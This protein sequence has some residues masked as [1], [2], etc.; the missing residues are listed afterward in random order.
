[1]DTYLYLLVHKEHTKFKIGL[2]I[3]VTDRS[4]RLAREQGDFD[5]DES[6]TIKNNALSISRLEKTLHFIF[7]DWNLRGNNEFEGHTEW[8]SI[9]CL[10]DVIEEIKRIGDYQGSN[11]EISKGVLLE[12]SR[13]LAASYKSSKL[14][15][16]LFKEYRF[17]ALHLY[18][19]NPEE[20]YHVR[21]AARIT[22]T[23]AG[24]LHKELKALVDA[25]LLKRENVGSL[26]TYQANTDCDIYEELCSIFNKIQLVKSKKLKQKHNKSTQ[27]TGNVG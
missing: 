12:K 10:K 27:S 6:Y 19:L 23:I 1:M 24:T 17:R 8:F 14:A 15:H 5:L 25:G 11:R 3:D 9:E 4:N 18:L 22:E 20:S 21:E 16:I 26:V 2:T 7:S 13:T